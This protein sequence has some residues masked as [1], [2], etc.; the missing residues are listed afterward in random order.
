MWVVHN[1]RRTQICTL[2][3]A[4]I[5]LNPDKRILSTV[6]N[7]HPAAAPAPGRTHRRCG[8]TRGRR[9][10]ALLLVR[11]QRRRQMEPF[12]SGLG[13]RPCADQPLSAARAIDKLARYSPTPPTPRP[14]QSRASGRAVIAGCCCCYG[15][16]HVYTVKYIYACVWVR[17]CVRVV[18]K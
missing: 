14:R 5:H 16:A 2:Y 11:S 7:T 3:T 4:H 6:A 1:M 18:R 15:H 12:Q 17:A 10:R 9:R 13:G 8:C